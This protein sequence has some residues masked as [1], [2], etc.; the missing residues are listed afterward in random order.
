LPFEVGEEEDVTL[1]EG[2]TPLVRIPV[3]DRL[4]LVK[5]EHQSPTLSFKDRG[6]VMLALRAQRLGAG[7]MVVDSSGNAG[8]AAAAYAAR[9]GIACRVFVPSAT[10]GAKVAI[11]RATGAEVC[12]VDGTR[13]DVAA[14]AIG[15]LDAS[16]VYASHVFDPLFLEGTKTF[17]FETWEQLGRRAPDH[18]VLPA[19]NG[20]LVLGA[21]LGFGELL[22][23]GL[24]AKHP[25]IVAVQAEA[26]AP[27]ATAFA[28]GD[29]TVASAVD[30]GTS[31]RGIAIGA[32]PRGD[33][34]LAAVR[35]TGGDVLTV[36]ED[37][38]ARARR[39]AARSGL[40]IDPSAA[41]SLAGLAKVGVDGLVVGCVTGWGPADAV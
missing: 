37:E 9:A 34:I 32:P 20:T 13:E 39:G 17:A 29:A 35:E 11:I 14:A 40:S 23:A 33:A 3:R 30:R 28:K 12:L 16:A 25:R 4:A 27:I 21:Y 26:C 22:A 7:T 38:I 19:G 36:S 24:I 10:P 18:L 5:L 31:A 8:L 1:G 6:A 41:A 2:M 15:A